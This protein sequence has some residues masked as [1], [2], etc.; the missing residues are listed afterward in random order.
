MKEYRDMNKAE[1]MTALLEKMDVVIEY[2][3]LSNDK[4]YD[5]LMVLRDIQQNQ[6]T[7]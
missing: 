4:L 5:M 1:Q 6:K 7:P 3:K 2:L